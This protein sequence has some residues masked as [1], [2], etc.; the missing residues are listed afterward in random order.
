[1]RKG[2]GDVLLVGWADADPPELALETDAVGVVGRGGLR[3]EGGAALGLGVFV[4]VLILLSV[5]VARTY[6]GSK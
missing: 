4:V 6:F 3:K 2:G 5:S 1:M